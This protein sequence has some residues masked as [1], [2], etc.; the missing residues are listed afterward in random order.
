MT[1][2]LYIYIFYTFFKLCVAFGYVCECVSMDLH[3]YIAFQ[4]YR[5]LKALYNTCDSQPF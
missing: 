1:K 4:V 5:F 3:L 2:I